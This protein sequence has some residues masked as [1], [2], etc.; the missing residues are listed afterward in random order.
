MGV[1]IFKSGIKENSGETPGLEGAEFTIKLNSAVEKAYQQGYTYA[2]VWNGIDEYGNKVGVDTKR[3]TEAQAIAPTYEVIKTDSDGNAYTQNKLPYGKFVVKETKTPTDYESA[4]DFTF[5]I[6]DDETEINEIAKK[7]K[8]LVVNNEQLETYIKLV[9][10]DKNTEKNVTLNSTTFEIKATKDIYDRATKKILFKKGETI[11]SDILN[12]KYG[13]RLNYYLKG[14]KVY[15]YPD[16]IEALNYEFTHHNPP[17]Y[18]N[19]H[20]TIPSRYK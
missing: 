2:E 14:G 15:L 3:V 6:T 1:H 7:T 13:I 11:Y 19:S 18:Y 5:S 20:F 9:K 16:I 17:I 4:A 12:D 8:H 10:K